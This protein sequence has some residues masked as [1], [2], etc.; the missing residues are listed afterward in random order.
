MASKVHK[1]IRLDA[2]TVERVRALM[3]DGES[4]SA[5]YVRVMEAGLD[6]LEG[7]PAGAAEDSAGDTRQAGTHGDDGLRD[8]LAGSLEA[9]R[10]QLGVMSAQLEAKDR[11]IQALTDLAAQSQTIA[12]H[13]QALHAM[14][15]A[16]AIGTASTGEH[17]GEHDQDTRR[18][19]LMGWLRRRGNG[20][21]A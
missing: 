10:E 15:E 11:Q 21:R 3:R 4:E 20:G 9:L 8:A 19:G 17:T 2:S 16:K 1:S 7:R 18:R 12:E 14:T 6:A 13:S 5:A